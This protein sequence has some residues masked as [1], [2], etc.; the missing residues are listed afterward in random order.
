MCVQ[1]ILLAEIFRNSI[2]ISTIFLPDSR[3]RYHNR[4]GSQI[5]D[6]TPGAI[7]C[8][9]PDE[10][11]SPQES[12]SQSMIGSEIP[13]CNRGLPSHRSYL[14]GCRL[15]HPDFTT[16]DELHRVWQM[17]MFSIISSNKAQQRLI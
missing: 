13:R 15:D 3:Y 17:I 5:M 4:Q 6:T 1:A 2:I 9:P 11:K 12:S 16:S 10:D 14:D 7:R 8:H